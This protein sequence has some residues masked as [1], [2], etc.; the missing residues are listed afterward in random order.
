VAAPPAPAVP[1]VIVQ[2]DP[3]AC[4]YELTRSQGRAHPLFK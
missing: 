2:V 1:S 4:F 3:K